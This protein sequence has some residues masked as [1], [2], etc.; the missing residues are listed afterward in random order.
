MPMVMSHGALKLAYRGE[1]GRMKLWSQARR[2]SAPRCAQIRE[3]TAKYM[4]GVRD[5]CADFESRG[6]IGV[7]ALETTQ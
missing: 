6:P 3:T 1:V 4:P 2:H 7:K 5:L